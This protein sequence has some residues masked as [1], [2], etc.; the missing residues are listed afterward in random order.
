MRDLGRAIHRGGVQKL[1]LKRPMKQSF[2]DYKYL[3]GGTGGK[4]SLWQGPDHLLVVEGRGFLLPFSEVYRRVDYDKIQAL[5]LVA[6]KTYI[7]ASVG[8]GLA[9]IFF[10]GMAF[11][12]RDEEPFLPISLLIPGVMLTVLLLINLFRGSTCRCSLQTAVQVL[13]LKPLVRV[14]KAEQVMALLDDLC[15]RQQA[16]LAH[17]PAAST[18]PGVEGVGALPLAPELPGAAIPGGKPPWQGSNWTFFTGL[19]MLL[20]GAALAAEL[21]VSGVAL[22]ISSVVLGTAVVVLGIIALVHASRYRTPV[23]LLVCLWGNLATDLL[24]GLGMYILAVAAVMHQGMS[25]PEKL[26]GN[27]AMGNEHIISSLANYSME[28]CE[29]WGWALVVLGGLILILGLSIVV[30]GGRG[31]RLAS[32]EVKASPPLP[33]PLDPVS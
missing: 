30:Y 31:R 15:R 5:S 23:T 33:P 1:W 29:P 10:L 4:G 3:A 16:G 9:A 22:T 24:A 19:L 25:N 32:E 28:Q 7:W 18:R 12:A 2:D 6:T 26:F 17:A 20:W 13:R 8:M 11:L 27:K 14:H 21:F